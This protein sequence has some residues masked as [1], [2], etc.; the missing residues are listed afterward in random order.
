MRGQMSWVSWRLA[1]LVLASLAASRHGAAAEPATVAAPPASSASRELFVD[2][3]F[4]H[5]W[6]NTFGARIGAS[7]PALVV[8]VR[9]GVPWL[10][11]RLHYTVSLDQLAL[12]TNGEQSRVGFANLDVLL[13]RELRVAGER[14]MILGGVAGGFVHTSQG[15]GP[16]LGS[17]IGV[18]YLIDVSSRWAVGPFFDL[19]WQAYKLP[20]SDRPLYAVEGSLVTSH[21]DAQAQIGVA[22]S[23]R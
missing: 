22:F 11:L 17:V 18:R 6:S 21:S 20:G 9:P 7:T 12:P 16:A 14:M 3:G 10:E 19:R 5:W 23:Y 13:E 1:V 15:L 8:G 4:S 2:V